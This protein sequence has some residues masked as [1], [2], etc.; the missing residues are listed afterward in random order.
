MNPGASSVSAAAY[1]HRQSELEVT[2]PDVGYAS[3]GTTQDVEDTA[4]DAM[5]ASQQAL[6]ILDAEVKGLSGGLMALE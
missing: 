6:M 2:L 4:H 1:V 5:R 3:G